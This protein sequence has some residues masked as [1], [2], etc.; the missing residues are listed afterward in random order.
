MAVALSSGLGAY[1]GFK[2]KILR[3][4]AA[5]LISCAGVILSPLGIWLAHQLPN[6]P[7]VLLFAAILSL[8]AKNMWSQAQPIQVNVSTWAGRFVWTHHKQ[9]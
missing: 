3:Y 4:K 7:L 2:A 8:V 6:W 9:K 1:L 5:L